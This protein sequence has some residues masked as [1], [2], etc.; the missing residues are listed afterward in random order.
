[1]EMLATINSET[2]CSIDCKHKTYGSGK[3]TKIKCS[4][5]LGKP[6]LF[7]TFE[8]ETKTTTFAYTIVSKFLEFDESDALTMENLMAEYLE[9][10]LEFDTN[11]K[12]EA[13]AAREA[14]YAAEAKAKAEAEA[15]KKLEATMAKL[16][17]MQPEDVAAVCGTPNTEFET[18]GWLAKHCTSLK[19][20]MPAEAQ[21]WFEAKF[22]KVANAKVYDAGAKTSG[23]NSMKYTL[24]I[25]GCFNA[26][27]P[28][29][30]RRFVPANKPKHI[31]SV[32]LFWTLVDKYG[33]QFGK[34]QDIDEI[35]KFVP[36]DYLSDFERGLEM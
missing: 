32:E 25:D 34:K 4:E 1:M 31:S 27:V 35:K 7:I 8:S 9:N 2:L 21:N 5:N 18:I 15:Q 36:A 10:W 29:I 6:D 33:F 14:K 20:S 28:S 23:G 12:A 11:R 26:E 3:I 17:R 19:P 13:K 30:L 16:D 22:G 24:S